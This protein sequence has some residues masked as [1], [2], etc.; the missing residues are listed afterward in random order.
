VRGLDATD[1][2]N[3]KV[4]G[5][6]KLGGWVRDTRVVGDVLYAVSEDY[7]WS[8]GWGVDAVPV[9]GAAGSG[10]VSSGQTTETVIVSS[11]SFASN[12]IA[13]VGKVEFT[14]YSGI[15]NDA[16]PI[17]M[18]HQAGADEGTDP[19]STSTSAIRAARSSSAALTVTVPCR[20]GA[21]TT[22]AGT[23]TSPTA[24]RARHRREVLRRGGYAVDCGPLEPRRAAAR[25][26][27]IPT[28]GWASPR[29]STRPC[30]L[31]RRLV[32][33]HR[34]DAV[35]VYDLAT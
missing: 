16:E 9:G 22:G 35:Q 11:V 5:E 2:S 14:G 3:I 24:D 30:T 13:A 6:A 31:A 26:A 34:H 33:R 1:P 10:T 21:R 17:M 15:F 32:R 27:A 20:A 18:A 4:L 8:Y 23:S 7:G 25:P 28:P 12:V 19:L 29:A